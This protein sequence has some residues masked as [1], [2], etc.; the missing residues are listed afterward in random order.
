KIV[1][2]GTHCKAG[3]S[4]AAGECWSMGQLSIKRVVVVSDTA[5]IRRVLPENCDNSEKDSDP[6]A[7]EGHNR[8]TPHSMTI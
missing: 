6:L 4:V 3:C 2:N 5:A 1:E 8:R 7:V